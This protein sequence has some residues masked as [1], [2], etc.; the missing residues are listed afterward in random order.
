MSEEAHKTY[1]TGVT[2]AE[3][4]ELTKYLW[5]GTKMFGAVSLVAHILLFAF[6]PW[7]HYG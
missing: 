6:S 4:E 3:A 2:M 5:D 1:T 7:G